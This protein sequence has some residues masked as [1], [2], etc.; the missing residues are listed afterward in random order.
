MISHRY[1]NSNQPNTAE[2]DCN[3]PQRSLIYLDANA[4]YSWAMSQLLPTSNFEWMSEEEISTF[5]PQ[6]IDAND[7]VGYIIEVKNS[8]FLLK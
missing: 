8:Y 1:V 2:Y 7:G 6:N 3:Q 5:N 4:L